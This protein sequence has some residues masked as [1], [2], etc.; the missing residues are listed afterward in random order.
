MSIE[1]EPKQEGNKV[2]KKS[3]NRYLIGLLGAAVIAIGVFYSANIFERKTELVANGEWQKLEERRE[4][5]VT[6][7]PTV[8]IQE[9]VPE[10]IKVYISG[11]IKNPDVY[12]LTNDS[13]ISDLIK[14]AG[15]TTEDADLEITNLSARIYDEQHIII[16]KIGEP[17]ITPEPVKNTDI[18]KKQ[19]TGDDFTVTREYIA[20]IN[21]NSATQEELETLPGVG[22]VTAK[23]IIA[24][25]DLNGSFKDKSDIQDIDRIGEK[26][27]EALKDYIIAE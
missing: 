8:I 19:K 15:G 23:K 4:P 26:T 3:D 12:E 1:N 5:E 10:T 24:Y 21:I 27:Y 6:P 13:R 25:R 14:L 16:P 11:A 17:L 7:S 9:A 2:N 18:E 20:P 22:E